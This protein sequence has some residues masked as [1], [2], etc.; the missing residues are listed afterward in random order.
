MGVIYRYRLNMTPGGVP[1][2]V[3]VNQYD[4]MFTL[5]FDLYALVNGTQFTIPEDT[6]AMVQGTKTDGCAYDAD[7]YLDR[8]TKQVTVDGD[9][10][11]TASAGKNIFEIKLINDGR[12]LYSA[13]FILDVEPAA[14][15][16]NSIQDESVLKELN[17]II[18]SAATATAAAETATEAAESVSESAAQI[19][20]NKAAVERL[21]YNLAD[22]N[23][24]NLLDNVTPKNDRTHKGIT[25]HWTDATNCEVEGTSTDTAFYPLF[26]N[27]AGFPDWLEKGGTY[28]IKYSTTDALITL[29]IW[30]YR[31]GSY[32]E[33]Y[34]V[35]GD[36]VWTIP[37]DVDG[38]ILRL[39][40][41]AH[42]QIVARQAAHGT[43]IDDTI[44]P[45]GL[46][47]EVG[48]SKVFYGVDSTLAEHRLAVRLLHADVESGDNLASHLVF[49]R[50]IDA[51][52]Q[53]YMI[54]CETGYC[55]HF[56][57]LL[58]F[59]PFIFPRIITVTKEQRIVSVFNTSPAIDKGV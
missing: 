30:Y 5:I 31:G 19:A 47:T 2:V 53:V 54:Y 43:P 51:S 20:L 39:Q 25:F 8:E 37:D 21:D 34:T 9:P 24:V 59:I 58:I 22:Y 50:D 41:A 18:E 38:L 29:I 3:H 40:V 7:C 26:S 52:E 27:T 16:A 35:K 42:K 45:L 11:M 23:C 6:T 10:Q 13:N 56:M 15:D 28:S 1:L 17:A 4:E 44:S 55:L 48:G 33:G 49:A 57:L 46:I 36:Y 32:S 14:M 12:A